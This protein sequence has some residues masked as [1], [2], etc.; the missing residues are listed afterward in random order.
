[1]QFLDDLEARYTL[2]PHAHP[3]DRHK[4]I[5][6]VQHL[7]GASHSSTS[8]APKEWARLELR[9]HP[10]LLDSWFNFGERLRSRYQNTVHRQIKVEERQALKQGFNSVQ[11]YKQVFELLC[12]QTDYSLNA[13]GEEFYKGLAPP[14]KDK[15]ACVT[16]LDRRDFEMVAH[17]AIQFDE[18]HRSRQREKQ[19]EKQTFDSSAY[20][21]P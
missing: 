5:V 7:D 1:M 15:L 19:A 17:H 14:I 2:Q 12:H 11:L 16:G 9:N 6:A 20:R 18:N 4:V 10:E 8:T 21:Q 13:W 3:T